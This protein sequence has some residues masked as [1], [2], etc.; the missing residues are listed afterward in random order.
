MGREGGARDHFRLRDVPG[1]T[2]AAA[3]LAILGAAALVGAP[4]WLWYRHKRRRADALARQPLHPDNGQ[5]E[6]PPE[7]DAPDEE[8]PTAR[9]H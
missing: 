4:L 3:S 1:T 2:L 5:S 8:Q 7:P 6:T 9:G